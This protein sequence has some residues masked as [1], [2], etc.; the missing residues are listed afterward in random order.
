MRCRF[1]TTLCLL[2]VPACATAQVDTDSVHH[3]NRCR[4]A[5]QAVETSRPAPH[6]E[7]AYR[8]VASCGEGGADALVTRM[9]TLRV[10][11][12]TA[13]VRAATYPMGYLRDREIYEASLQLAGDR[14]ASE[15]A[16]VFA[17]RNLVWMVRPDAGLEDF[18]PWHEVSLGCLGVTQDQD[19]VELRP[20]PADYREVIRD[21]ARRAVRDPSEPRPI[22]KSAACVLSFGGW[23]SDI[24]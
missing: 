1:I 5:V 14:A 21:F 4:L 22:R 20:L 7:W 3:R 17:F 8:Y 23:S 24:P 12:D 9:R 18:D 6:N 10:S 11:S 15:V 13:T 2:L 16:R 19:A